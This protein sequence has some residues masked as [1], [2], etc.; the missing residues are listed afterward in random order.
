MMAGRV[1]VAISADG[2]EIVGRVRGQGPALVLVHGGWGDGEVAYEALVPLLADRFTCYTPS[3]RGRGLS[4]DNP[5]HSVHRLAQ[6]VIAFIDTIGEPVCLVGWSGIEPPLGAAAQSGAVSAM[7][8][9]EGYVPTV[10]EEDDL[11][12]LGATI[13]RT[14]AAA[15]DGRLAA[16]ARAFAPF[17]LTG[18]E[19]A[20]LDGDFFE[21]W[22]RSI[23]AMLQYFRQNLLMEGS[24]PCDPE[25]LAKISAPVVALWSRETTKTTWVSKS[26]LY[27]AQH[28]A[29][30]YVREL[31]GCG[32]GA[33]L[34]APE[35][36]AEELTS[37]F[38]SVR[39]NSSPSTLF[40]PPPYRKSVMPRTAGTSVPTYPPS[41]SQN[42]MLDTPAASSVGAPDVADR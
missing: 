16:A 8:L 7:A 28:V 12:S 40:T 17:V 34:V 13:E 21:R 38:E 10:A 1:Q 20:A 19:L 30:G 2:T 6:D 24:R 29:D 42:S 36:L 33:P 31:T 18:A 27:L 32:H 22:G 4:G 39:A 15:A 35:V 14:D 23:P 26:A 5:D 9:F 37:F 25:Q 11:A 3:T 41:H